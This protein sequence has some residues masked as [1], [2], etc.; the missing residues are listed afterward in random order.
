MIDISSFSILRITL[1]FQESFESFAL[2]PRNQFI[3]HHLTVVPNLMLQDSR[4]SKNVSHNRLTEQNW[5]FTDGT[6]KAEEILSHIYM[7]NGFAI[8]NL[9]EQLKFAI[10]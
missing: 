2:T 10:Q 4:H 3:P 6:S 8:L 1:T 9:S 7:N 5:Y